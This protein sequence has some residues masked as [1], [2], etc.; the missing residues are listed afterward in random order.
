[1]ART[2][3]IL[4]NNHVVENADDVEVTTKDNRRFRARI[5]GRDPETDIAV[6]KVDARNL[7]A[8]GHGR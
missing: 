1:M 2:V 4:T 3:T 8:I 6:L 7:K 5:I